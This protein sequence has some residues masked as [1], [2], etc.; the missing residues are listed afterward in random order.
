MDDPI[1]DVHAQRKHQGDPRQKEIKDLTAFLYLQDE[2]AHKDQQH[3]SRKLYHADR[4]VQKQTAAQ[5]RNEHSHHAKNTDKQIAANLGISA[6]TLITWKSEHPELGEAIRDG[7]SHIIRHVEHKLLELIDGATDSTVVEVE[8]RP[9][10]ENGEKVGIK[11]K[12]VTTTKAKPDLKAISL[13][14]YNNDERY[15]ESMNKN[16]ND[17]NASESVTIIDDIGSGKNA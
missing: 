16:K 8:E 11:N 10:I 17:N 12:T 15:K 5:K 3:D 1:Q 6:R 13:Y 4:V 7:R 14:L 2:E 9:I